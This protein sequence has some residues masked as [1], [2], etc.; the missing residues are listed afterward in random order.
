MLTLFL[1]LIDYELNPLIYSLLALS[2]L[3]YAG[4]FKIE[5]L[6]ISVLI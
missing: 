3:L 4:V 2:L 6:S 5:K 1:D